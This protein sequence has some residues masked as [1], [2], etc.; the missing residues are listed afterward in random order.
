MESMLGNFASA[1]QHFIRGLRIMHQYRSRPAMT[2]N[3]R[4]VPCGGV[5][6]LHP[7]SFVIKLF[8]SGYPGPLPMAGR[9]SAHIGPPTTALEIQ[10]CDQARGELAALSVQASG[11]LSSLS[12]L[13]TES[14]GA[15]LQ[16]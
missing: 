14:Q 6:L 11:F 8:A 15:E 16:A 3:G 13:R 12:N 7:D 1:I 4:V 9:E 2:D 5:S 10:L